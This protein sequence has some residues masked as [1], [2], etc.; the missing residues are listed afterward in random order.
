MAVA[1][2]VLFQ[3]TATNYT[4]TCTIST[5]EEI[6]DNVIDPRDAPNIPANAEPPAIVSPHSTHWKQTPFQAGGCGCRAEHKAADLVP[7]ERSWT[8]MSA[9]P[10]PSYKGPE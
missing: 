4:R 7:W 1:V 9:R 2:Q 8:A 5:E 3:S 10:Q 6:R